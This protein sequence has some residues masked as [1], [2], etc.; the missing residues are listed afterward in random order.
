MSASTPTLDRG[1]AFALLAAGSSRRAGGGKLGFLLENKPLLLW[2]AEA[3]ERAGFQ[4]RYFIVASEA[5][6]D[7][8]LAAKGWTHVINREAGSG[9]ASSIR[10]AA[11]AAHGCERLVI[12]LADMPFVT[13]AHLRALA[14]SRG[15]AFTRYPTGRN[16]VPA[17][18]D[19]DDLV[20]FDRLE[21]DAGA[22]SLA[23]NSAVSVAPAAQEELRDI[24]T[25]QDLENARDFVRMRQVH[26]GDGG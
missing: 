24:D 16:G 21:G 22:A 25:L 13:P 1:I 3:A 2:S 12:A 14:L 15:P 19:R 20:R 6:P 26:S 17:G 8:G 18:F 9:I 11:H 10:A 23:W 4:T 5:L 7:A